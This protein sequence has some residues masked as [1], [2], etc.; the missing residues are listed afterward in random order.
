TQARGAG[1]E[2]PGK[3]YLSWETLDPRTGEA[4]RSLIALD[5]KTGET[6]RIFDRC[7]T[8]PRISPD[9]LTVAYESD[10]SLWVR[11]L[12]KK[13]TPKGIMDLG[14]ATSG[15]PP[16]WSPNGK[17]LVIS[18]APV[19]EKPGPW[20]FKTVRVNVD[21][22]GR[23]ELAIPHEDG[24]EDWSSDGRWLLTASSR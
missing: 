22:T 4:V 11:G 1:R 6:D 12:D 2:R 19:Q 18:L 21:G 7:S 9:G 20:V 8:R 10:G 23:Q 24:V 3:L 5:P 17:E 16:V 15:S 13:A 14:G